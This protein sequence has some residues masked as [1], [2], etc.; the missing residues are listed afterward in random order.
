MF[1]RRVAHTVVL[2][3]PVTLLTT[4]KPRMEKWQETFR[5]VSEGGDPSATALRGWAAWQVQVGTICPTDSAGF[6]AV[7]VVFEAGPPTA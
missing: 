2:E 5:T 1:Y 7:W 4:A 6:S 3:S